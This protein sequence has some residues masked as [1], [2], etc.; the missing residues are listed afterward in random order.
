MKQEKR[1]RF[2]RFVFVSG[3]SF[4]NL[5]GTILLD[6]LLPFSPRSLGR[7]GGRRRVLQICRKTFRCT[8]FLVKT[9][10]FC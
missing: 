4:I 7:G 10:G 2:G 5:T 9:E 1:N 8:P 6:R 3:G